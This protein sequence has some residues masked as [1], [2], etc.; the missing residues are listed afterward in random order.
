MSVKKLKTVGC[1]AMALLLF[2]P[3]FVC[4]CADK[5]E[6]TKITVGIWRGTSAAEKAFYEECKTAFEKRYPQYELSFSPYVY[7]ADTVVSKYAS[8]Q[9]PTL[10]EAEAA[11]IKSAARNGYIKDVSG[12]MSD[13]GWTERADGYFISQ[14]SHGKTVYGVPSEQYSVGMAL[15][16]PLLH[17]AGVIERDAAGK[18][19]LYDGETPLYP[20]TFEELTAAARRVVQASDGAYGIFLPSGDKRCGEIYADIIYN[21]GCDGLEYRE[22]DE[23]KLSLGDEATGNALRWVKALAQEGC[24]DRSVMYDVNDWAAAFATGSAAFAFCGSNSLVA[25]LSAEPALCGN[26]AFVPVPTASCEGRSVWNGTVYAVSGMA[27]DEQT[28]GA[29]AFLSFMGYG[30]ETDEQ[31]L[32]YLQR[33]VEN[34]Y[35]DVPVVPELFVWNDESYQAKVSEIYATYEAAN[36]EYF[37]AFFDGFD[38]RKREGEPYARDKV[39]SLLN[40]LFEKMIFDA[41]T[42]DIVELISESEKKFNE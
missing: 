35:L 4:A 6:R 8:G 42:V 30:P 27:T 20:D 40:E 29:F 31:S 38:A 34:K 37:R 24:A 2:T 25:A 32:Y 15:N 36:A 23:W 16:L 22:G 9:L 28:R 12:F 19:V 11:E 21:F 18:Y 26:I 1:A 13:F 14:I 5:R 41:T 17:K 10:F 3:A 7:G 33:R 39:H